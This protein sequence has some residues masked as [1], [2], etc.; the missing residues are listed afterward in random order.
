MMKVFLLYPDRDFDLSRELPP[1]LADLSQDLALNTLFAAM[2]QGDEFLSQVV[3]RVV[4]SGLDAIEVIAYRQ[5]ILKDCLKHPDVIRQIYSI[6]LEFLERKRKQWLWISPRLAT[7]PS[8]ILS[9]ARSLLEASLDLLRRLRQIA[10]VHAG[11]FESRG[12]RR[13]F[14]M[15]QQEL[16]DEYLTLVEK[17][18][19]ALRFPNG[20]LLSAQLGR[21]NEGT[22]YILCK[23]NDMDRNWVKRVFASKSP[24]YSFTLHPRDDRGAQVLGELRDRGLARAASAVAQAAEHIESF[25]NVLRWE[26]A[27]YVG[28]LNLY[29]QLAQ[30]GEPVAF[31]QPV[32]ADERRFSCTELYDVSLALTM[33]RKVV[34]NDVVA[35]GKDLVIITG[36]NQGGKT[37]FLRSVGLAQLMMQAG[38]FVPAESFSSNLCSSLFTHFKREEDKTMERGKFE[39]ELQRMSAMVDL[40]KPND[41]ILLNESFASTNEREGS[42]IARQVVSALLDA[43]IKVFYVTHLYEF[44]RRIQE[45]KGRNVLF[46]R[47]ERLADGSRT[48]KV[49]EGDPLETGY[50]VDLYNKIFKAEEVEQHVLHAS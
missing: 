17:H 39:E 38:M 14:A 20:V 4:L 43:G 36:P 26:L 12:L 22:H 47:A 24:V 16:D 10:D 30:L 25:L 44:A 5:E 11:T 1:N 6:P 37:T 46:L 34:G 41:L 23:P 2:A 45:K 32:P 3:Q 28:C 21:G 40:I 19:R 15:I 50:G 42:E 8:L 48:F 29:E 7:S 31:P 33:K 27:F 18:I 13:F 9:G 49:K 35:D